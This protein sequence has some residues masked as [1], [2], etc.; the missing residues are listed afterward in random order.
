LGIDANAAR[1]P[2]MTQTAS[3]GTRHVHSEA[4]IR[5]NIG[6]SALNHFFVEGGMTLSDPATVLPLLIRELGGSHA[7]A[8]L[9]PSVRLFGWLLPQFFVAAPMQRLKR[10]LP[11]VR[12]LEAVRTLV[13]LLL[14]LLLVHH[15]RTNPGLFLTVV[16]VLFIIARLAAGSSAVARS[17]LVAR[18]VPA[19]QRSRVVSMRSFTGDIGGFTAG[20]LIGYVLSAEGL[21]FPVNYAWLLGISGLSFLLAISALSMVVEPKGA[22]LGTRVDLWQQLKRAPDLLRQDQRFLRYIEARAATAAVGIAD[23][24]FILYATEV[25]GVSPAMSGVY[26][27]A[28][29]LVRLFSNLLWARTTR[30]R[31]NLW[32]FRVAR[33]LGAVEPLAVLLFGL[34]ARGIWGSEVPVIVGALFAVPFSLQGLAISADNISRTSYLYDIAPDQ[35]RPTYIGLSNTLLGPLQFLPTLGGL[36]VQAIGFPPIFVLATLCA[37]WS[38][39]LSRDMDGAEKPEGGARIQAR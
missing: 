17:E 11:T 9:V 7:V 20:I 34:L 10:F 2:S 38:Y 25:L 30:V 5:R 37:L 14:A 18:M 4:T 12:A 3:S 13:Y 16:F 35:E 32:T 33:L 29:M 15:D 19:G 27:S 1:M 23:P 28:R 22:P 36:L 8:G 26:L 21:A 39:F 6:W 31:G 24:F